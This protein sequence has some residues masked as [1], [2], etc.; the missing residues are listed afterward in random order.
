MGGVSKILIRVTLPLYQTNVGF[1][2]LKPYFLKNMLEE[3]PIIFTY[4]CI[5]FWVL[6]LKCYACPS[7]HGAY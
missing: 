2:M 7:L 6:I 4:T 3:T 1:N 5:L